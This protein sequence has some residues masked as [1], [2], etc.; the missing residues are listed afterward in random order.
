MAVFGYK[1][2]N[3]CYN[4]L[5]ITTEEIKHLADLARIEMTEAEAEKMTKEVDAILDYVGQIKEVSGNSERVLPKHRNVMR[6]DVVTNKTGEYTEAIMKNAPARE[7][8]YFK[9]KKIL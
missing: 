6:E 1:L 7:G 4:A 2:L 3:F 5:M 8:K 9:V